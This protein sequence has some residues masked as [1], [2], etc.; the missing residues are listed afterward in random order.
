Q[1]LDD[2]VGT[3]AKYTR[4]DSK[5]SIIFMEKYIAD[6]GFSKEYFNSFSDILF[7]T[8]LDAKIKEMQFKSRQIELLGKMLGTADLL[9][10]MADRTYLEKLLFLFYEFREGGIMGYDNELDLLK[11]TIDFYAMARK[12]F[13]SELDSMYE[14]MR[15]HF[16]ARWNLDRN[17][18]MEAIES[19]INYLKFILENHEKDYRDH[20]KRDGIVRKLNE[21][22]K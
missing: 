17:L 13:V 12:R 6:N 20:L 9:G 15:Y 1:T 16:K 10:Q 3:G 14:Y 4:I 19:H 5:R 11:K 7:C 18:Y 22:P 21:K 8:S 2:N